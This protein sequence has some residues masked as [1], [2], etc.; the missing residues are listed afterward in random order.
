MSAQNIA[1]QKAGEYAASFIETDMN[2]GIGTGSTVYYFIQALAKRIKEG[3]VIKG[4]PTSTQTE[5]LA[6]EL[7]IPL[8]DLNKVAQLDLT[9]DGADEID[10]HLQLIKG[11][12]GALLQEKIVAAASKKLIIIA[13]ESKLV[14]TLGK[15]PLPVE[16]IA[17]AWEQTQKHI[18]NIGCNKIILRKKNDVVFMTDHKHYILDCYFEKIND[19]V[20]LTQQ[21][22]NIPGVVENGLFV[23]MATSAIIA[24]NDGS[25]AGLTVPV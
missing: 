16:V 11:G 8:T 14:D 25:V 1:K 15:F 23:N 6:K 10:P 9:V 2:I 21:L 5:Q 17:F 22:N 19:V 3:L 13:D 20:S 7:N 24:Y 4:V 18:Q 12:G